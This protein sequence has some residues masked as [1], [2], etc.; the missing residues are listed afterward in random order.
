MKIEKE[1]KKEIL[2]KIRS[3]VIE[4]APRGDFGQRL[5]LLAYA[6]LRGVPYVAV[7]GKINEDHPSFGDGRNTFLD[8]LAYSVARSICNRLFKKIV[9]EQINCF[10]NMSREERDEYHKKFKEVKSEVYEWMMK[11]Y[12][13]QQE[14]AE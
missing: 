7:E 14:A 12:E 6:F 13:A 11:K 5:R 2:E 10:V 1:A 3:S 9:H 4:N 8:H